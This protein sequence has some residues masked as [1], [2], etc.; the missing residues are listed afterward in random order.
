MVF[1]KKR[2]KNYRRKKGHRQA[3]TA[4][5]IA[6]GVPFGKK[7]SKAAPRPE[8]KKAEK[9]PQA[10]AEVKAKSP[11]KPAAKKAEAKPAGKKRA[12]KALRLAPE[13]R[14]PSQRSKEA[15]HG[16]QHVGIASNQY[17]SRILT[18]ITTPLFAHAVISRPRS[19]QMRI[20][21]DSHRPLLEFV[22]GKRERVGRA[23]DA[24]A[25]ETPM[26]G[27]GRVLRPAHRR[28]RN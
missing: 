19:A 7:P 1:K 27:H 25:P 14:Q 16:T 24:G 5:R 13:S 9:K 2:R 20:F 12:A 17:L 23:D 22:Q 18:S 3:L 28:R 4:L 26:E 10:K 6:E 15:R 21:L 8:P 11:A